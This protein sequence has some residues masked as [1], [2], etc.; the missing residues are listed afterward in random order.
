MYG[1]V[2][3]FHTRNKTVVVK[4][5]YD[6]ATRLTLTAVRTDGSIDPRFGSHGRA[7]I[8]TPWRGRYAELNTTVLSGGAGRRAI[9]LVRHYRPRVVVGFGANA[10]R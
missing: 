3:A 9:T 7:G 5:P 1:T 4:S 6:D 10:S 8:R 2:W